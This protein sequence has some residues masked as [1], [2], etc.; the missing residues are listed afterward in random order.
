[1]R[2][3]INI[4]VTCL[5]LLVGNSSC[6]DFLDL[7]PLNKITE[8]DVFG[9]TTG[10]DAYFSVLYNR[11]PIEDFN[12]G[13]E[14]GFNNWVSGAFFSMMSCDE[15]IH[16][17]WSNEIFGPMGDGMWHQW[18]AYDNV[19]NV[20]EL[21]VQLRNITFLDD[22][23]RNIYLGEAYAIRAWYYFGMA[24]RYGGIPII[25]EPQQYDPSNIEPLYVTRNT[26]EETYNF[27]L[28]ELDEA[29]RLLP[30]QRDGNEYRFTKY[31]AA[32]LKTRAMLFAASI[33]KYGSYDLN[34]LVGFK[35]GEEVAKKYYKEV[36]NAAEI[37]IGSHKFDLYRANA[38]LEKN[39]QE[40]FWDK[41]DCEEVLFVKRFIFP[42]KTHCWDLFQQ[43][44]GYRLA[45]G[46]GS[47]TSP[48]LDL[49][50]SFKKKDGTSGRLQI[51]A[52]GWVVD[53]NGKI[54]EFED[55]TDLF[56]GRDARLNAT[57]LVP[58]S[59]WSSANGDR[60]GII[61]VK[62]GLV[63]KQ[64][65]NITI[66]KEGGSFTDTY[67]FSGEN[68]NVIGAQGIGGVNESTKTG[69]Y[70][71]KYLYEGN[72]PQDPKHWTQEQDWLEFRYAEVL[73]N[74][75]EAAAEL[76]TL[77]DAAYISDG[78]EYLNLVR[79]RAGV[80]RAD[81]LTVDMV[82]EEMRVEFMF[83]NHRMWDLKRWRQSATVMNNKKFKGLYPYYVLNTR[84]WIFK[85]LDVGNPYDFKPMM[86]YIRIN[87]GQ[88][89]QNPKLIQ[90][91]GY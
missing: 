30:E 27:I 65:E 90:N 73:L 4:I 59:K 48:T 12:Y 46:Y 20:N 15:A 87:T 18:W 70:I 7:P 13:G 29:I 38:D 1:M 23:T 10:L 8:N 35:E 17:E 9:S 66:V 55:R 16:G 88:I 60:T 11:L 81:N 56:A 54:E 67:N 85:K 26:E 83:E 86:Y 52:Q 2:K 68:I 50:E 63:V 84:K 51:N 25:K 39:Y 69:F 61:D 74:F 49:V 37:V 19:R 47:R 82:R 5:V 40:L 28:R 42:N 21:I 34:G 45:D 78:L 79:D 72:A 32:A 53:G 33:A 76:A 77:G 6:S 64:G 44:W 36:I 89:N 62:R 14:S 3:I 24:K 71:K 75:A 57:V 80:K 22:A 41:P 58:G 43:P 91:P 31:S